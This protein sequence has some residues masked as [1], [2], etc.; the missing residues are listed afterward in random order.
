MSILI[1][2]GSLNTDSKSRVLALALHAQLTQ[3]AIPCEFLDLATLELPLCDGKTSYGHPSVKLLNQ[4]ISAASGLVIATPI[5]NYGFNSTVKTLIE[6][7]GRAMTDKP[8][9]FLAAA[10]GHGS[11][12]AIMSLANALMLDFRCVILPRFVYAVESDFNDQNQ[13]IS[14]KITERLTQFAEAF[15]TFVRK[16]S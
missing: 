4:K 6:H 15:S 11:Y 7:A 5:Y 8:V 9:G 14:T 3:Q 2:S 1:L 16:L 10:G 12:M 13:I